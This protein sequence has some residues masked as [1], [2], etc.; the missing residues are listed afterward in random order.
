[1]FNIKARSEPA[2][3]EKSGQIY[4]KKMKLKILNFIYECL[5]SEISQRFPNYIFAGC[6]ATGVLGFERSVIIM[7]IMM[8]ATA[9]G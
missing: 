7:P 5:R 9:T 4:A 2:V 8:M 1:M 6:G 3:A